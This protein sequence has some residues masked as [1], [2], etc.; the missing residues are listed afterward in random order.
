MKTY[1]L[2]SNDAKKTPKG[3]FLFS[4]FSSARGSV[5]KLP[6]VVRSSFATPIRSLRSSDAGQMLRGAKRKTKAL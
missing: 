4:V 2:D 3:V 1:C 5:T 6:H